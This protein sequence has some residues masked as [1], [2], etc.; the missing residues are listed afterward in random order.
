M[1]K[2]LYSASMSLDG[3]IAGPGGDM[4][5]LTEH[6]GAPNPTAERLL[7]QVGAI[8]AGRGTFGGGDPNEGTDKEGAFGGE[9]HGPQF[10][11]TH[12]PPAEP[13][14]GVTF[15]GDLRTA[16]AEAKA[17]AGDRYVN[18]LGANVAAQ[19]L[20]EGILDEVLVFPVP[21]LLG[22]GTRLFEHPGGTRVR[23][24]PID[25]EYPH[26]YRVVR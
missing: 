26:W 10:V 24:Q 8:L 15:L 20:E 19:C 22:D 21:V 9:Y 13:V 5:W 25:D 18:L 4:S 6:L 16:V 1:A 3:F 23:L 14:P 12:R 11:L 17:A 2:L 7:G